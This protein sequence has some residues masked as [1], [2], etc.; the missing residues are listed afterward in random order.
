MEKT[1]AKQQTATKILTL[2]NAIIKAPKP[3]K[4]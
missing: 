4:K 1:T 2:P 3:A